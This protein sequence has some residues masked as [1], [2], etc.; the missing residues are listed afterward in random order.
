[1]RAFFGDSIP[2]LLLAACAGSADDPSNPP[3]LT[4]LSVSPA[5]G[6]TDIA[7]DTKITL[8]LSAAPPADFDVDLKS[9]GDPI[10]H[11][12]AISGTTVTITPTD[13]LWIATDY[14]LAVA[15]FGSKF[16]T[17]DG[18]WKNLELASMTMLAAGPLGGGAAPSLTTLADG[19]VLAGWEGGASV[20]DQ[21]FQPSTGWNAGP[22]QLDVVGDPGDVPVAASSA[23]RA[24]MGYGRY[25]TKDN[26]EARTYDGNQW[27]APVTV[28]PYTVGTTKYD[29]YLGNVAATNQ[30]FALVFHR[31][32]FQTDQMD[33][34]AAIHTNGTWSQPILVE[35]QAGEVS[36]G[37]IVDD[38]HGG[39]VIAWITRSVDKLS[40]AVWMTT[41]SA[42]GTVGTPQLLDDASGSTWSLSLARGGDT[43]WIAWGHQDGNVDLRVVARPL[44][45]SGLGAAHEIPVHGF[46]FGGEWVRIAAS[47]RGALVSYTQY[48]A[49]YAAQ[50]TN[51]AWSTIAELDKRPDNPN[52]EVGRPAIT[53][54][55]RG[56][57]TAVWTRVPQSG[58]RTTFVSRARAGTWSQPTQLDKG[59][60]ST[61]AWCA[62]VD[63]AGRVTTAWT[64][65]TSTGYTVWGAY[66]E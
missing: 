38:G 18:A 66:L 39:Y 22:G 17:R 20:F 14:D 16:G 3:D 21:K 7:L 59:T 19:T 47:A 1:M 54:D 48:G 58:R 10:A 37:D 24:V 42:S 8:E 44:S 55:D 33:L 60:D 31:G 56:N 13:P 30:T 27:S 29:Q 6:A 11:A 46:S 49:V 9:L 12:I 64:Q 15:T 25:I 52:D 40:T 45:P 36:G 26:I 2:L 61:Y 41:L 65:S 43:V 53:M 51:G 28:A 34:Y 57:A 50:L 63:A 5:N 62:G 35:Q 32:N 23:S 4:V